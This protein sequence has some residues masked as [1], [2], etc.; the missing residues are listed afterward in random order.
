MSEREQDLGIGSKDAKAEADLTRALDDFYG[1]DFLEDSDSENELDEPEFSAEEEES[2]MSSEKLSLEDR[3]AFRAK[4][5]AALKSML[6]KEAQPKILLSLLDS[7]LGIKVIDQM[8][9]FK[10]F[11]RLKSN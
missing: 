11:G 9:L 4:S 10:L 7:G 6:T 8:K 2:M 1:E 3:F 5:R